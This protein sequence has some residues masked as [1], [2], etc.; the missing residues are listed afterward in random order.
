MIS[1]IKI[2]Y[3]CNGQGGFRMKKFYFSNFSYGS[4]DTL[5]WKMFRESM[6]NFLDDSDCSYSNNLILQG[7][8]KCFDNDER[9]SYINNL[10]D[11]E[12]KILV[13]SMGDAEFNCFIGILKRI[14]KEDSVSTCHE[15]VFKKLIVERELLLN[16]VMQTVKFVREVSCNE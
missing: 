6:L 3:K 5:K 8:R 4:N 1:L 11:E 10:I 9:F 2:H 7:F 16:N 15:R 12:R 14:E 13:L